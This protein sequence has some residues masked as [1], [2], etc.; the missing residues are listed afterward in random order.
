MGLEAIQS[1]EL[2][3]QRR[4]PAFDVFPAHLPHVFTAITIIGSA[5]L[6]WY[7]SLPGA[8]RDLTLNVM[9]SEGQNV[10][11]HCQDYLRSSSNSVEWMCM[12]A[13]SPDKVP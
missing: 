4:R 1:W 7:L 12:S 5:I 3:K 13:R 2:I 10:L 6:T 11:G 9:S 8:N